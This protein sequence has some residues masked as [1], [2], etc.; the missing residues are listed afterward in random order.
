MGIAW[1]YST[2]LLGSV[3]IGERDPRTFSFA[4]DDVSVGTSQ[5]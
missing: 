3:D 4:V 2:D 5:R 1:N